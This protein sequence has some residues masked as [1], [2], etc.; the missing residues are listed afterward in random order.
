MKELE[1]LDQ[2]MADVELRL[3]QFQGRQR[4]LVRQL[5]QYTIVGLVIYLVYWKFG[6]P[7]N[8]ARL[9]ATLYIAVFPA[10]GLLCVNLYP[11]DGSLDLNTKYHRVSLTQGI[12]S[13]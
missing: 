4:F 6:L 9:E 7:E 2:K 8:P 11:C 10:I 1:K 5:I 13:R 3:V 12:S